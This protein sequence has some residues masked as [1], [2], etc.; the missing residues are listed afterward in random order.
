M[1]VLLAI[2]LYDLPIC[3]HCLHVWYH[4]LTR[5]LGGVAVRVLTSNLGGRWFESRARRFMLESWWLL[6]NARWF[7]VQ[8]ALV[9]STCKLPIAI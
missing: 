8:Y 5:G 7:T 4:T 3:L 6:A 2:V 1:C 9:S